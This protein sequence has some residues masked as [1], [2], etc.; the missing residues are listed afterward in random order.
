MPKFKVGDKIKVLG[1]EDGYKTGGLIGKIVARCN[2]DA[3]WSGKVYW[4]I[5]FNSEDFDEG[6]NLEG[7]ITGEARSGLWV[8]ETLLKPLNVVLE[9]K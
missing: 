5:I 9:N 1:N 6:H 8:R 4:G 2:D 3:D 7:R